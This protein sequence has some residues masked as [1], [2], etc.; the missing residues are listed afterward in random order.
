M[1]VIQV[2]FLLRTGLV[3]HS[4]K[5]T[6]D[7]PNE[8][9]VSPFI[10]AIITFAQASF[11]SASLSNI[12]IG[13]NLITIETGFLNDPESVDGSLDLLSIMTSTG[14]DDSTAHAILSELIEKF[15]VSLEEK[16]QSGE[17]NFYNLKGGKVA[18]LSYFNDTIAK[19][20]SREHDKEFLNYDLSVLV[21]KN[22]VETINLLFCSNRDIGEVYQYKE[23][24]MIEQLLLEYINYDLEAKLK[25]KFGLKNHI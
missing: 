21:P 3:L 15:A 19:I 9:F 25:E 22:I 13:Q 17:I 7:S 14:I 1:P 5:F 20:I 4:K 12:Q 8:E 11:K 6:Q 2:I 16:I 23:S 24:S 10:S 18:D